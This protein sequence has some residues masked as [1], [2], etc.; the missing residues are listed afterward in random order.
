MI[1]FNPET[2]GNQLES[3]TKIL[4]RFGSVHRVGRGGSGYN[5]IMVIRCPQAAVEIRFVKSAIRLNIVGSQ[6][7]FPRNPPLRSS[8]IPIVPKIE[9]HVAVESSNHFFVGTT[10]LGLD[11]VETNGGQQTMSNTFF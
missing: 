11:I 1:R 5:E 2:A 8:S 4:L 3:L 6:H 10:V 7:M 9:T